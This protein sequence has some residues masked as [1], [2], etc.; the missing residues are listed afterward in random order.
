MAK[1]KR[2]HGPGDGE[3]PDSAMP[4]YLVSES[5]REGEQPA[6]SVL[7]IDAAADGNEA[8]RARAVSALLGAERGM[9]FAAVYS[10]H[11]SWI[12]GVGGAATDRTIVF[13]LATSEASWGPWLMCPKHRPVLVS[14]GGEVFVLSRR[15]R[16]AR[17]VDYDPWFESFS[18]NGGASDA[19]V[20]RAYLP[21]PPFLPLFMDP[22]EYRNPPEIHISS[23]AAIGSHLLF[24]AQPELG[25][26]AFHVVS[27]TWEKI[28]DKNLPFVDQA[29]ALDGG[30]GGLFA[31]CRASDDPATAAVS[32]FYISI[33]VKETTPSLSIQEFPVKTSEGDISW[34]I[35]CPLGKGSFCS[36]RSSH[37]SRRR[38]TKIKV[39]LTAFEMENI[40]AVLAACEHQD[41]RVAVQVKEQSHTYRYSFEGRSHLLDS[42]TPVVA[43]LSL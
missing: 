29:M 6:Y 37:R 18:F 34:P 19:D 9:S 41:L 28:L 12:V 38:K 10:K 26:Y 16:F 4:I 30:G 36:I 25:T 23:Y 15:P 3:P 21:P 20:A 7:Q 2:K 32:L 22:Y 40:D 11:G 17:G 39:T 35:I 1:R 27:H 31:A 5:E 43:A 8:S 14:H 42:G 24:S 33:D 13:N